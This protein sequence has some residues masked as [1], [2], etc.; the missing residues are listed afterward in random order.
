MEP[1]YLFWL[2][3]YPQLSCFCFF[4]FP[5][6][7][8][9]LG[10]SRRVN[11]PNRNRAIFT[12]KTLL[13][14]CHVS[15]RSMVGNFVSCWQQIDTHHLW[16]QQQWNWKL[17]ILLTVCWHRRMSNSVQSILSAWVPVLTLLGGYGWLELLKLGDARDFVLLRQETPLKDSGILLENNRVNLSEEDWSLKS[18]DYR[19]RRRDYSKNELTRLRFQSA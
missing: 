12:V 6:S 10:L 4:N 19:Y 7:F 3:H 1:W 14:F 18:L 15:S 16:M 5:I 17:F 8:K 9:R 13:P 2:E 11:Q